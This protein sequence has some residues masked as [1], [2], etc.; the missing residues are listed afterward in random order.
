MI[1]KRGK[2]NII[3]SGAFIFICMWFLIPIVQVVT[4]KAFLLLLL[5]SWVLSSNWRYLIVSVFNN[6]WFFIWYMYMLLLLMFGIWKYGLLQPISFFVDVP[7]FFLGAII[8]SY[9]NTKKNYSLLAKGCIVSLFCIFIGSINS[10]FMLLQNP[11]ASRILATGQIQSKEF[12]NM[13]IGGYGYVYASVMFMVIAIYLLKNKLSINIKMKIFLLL[14]CIINF[15][16]IIKASYTIAILCAIFLSVL[17]IIRFKNLKLLL[18]TGIFIIVLF[19]IFK[20]Q[21]GYYLISLASYLPKGQVSYGKIL[22]LAQGFISNDFGPESIGRFDLYAKSIDVFC[23]SP[24]LGEIGNA[25]TY[26]S[27]GRHSAWFD[28]LGAFGLIGGLPIFVYLL[29]KMSHMI[30]LWK[31]NEYVN[32]LVIIQLYI[33][34]LGFINPIIY[35]YEIG[36][37]FFLLVPSFPFILHGKELGE[38]KVKEV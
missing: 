27:I 4:G 14:L 36:F 22:D 35:S 13:G 34:F 24:F 21:V 19:L 31:S 3:N 28:L 29:S 2:D 7:L 18:F 17:S 30:K 9:Y 32:Y 10:F 33:L 25:D 5:I 12:A 8:F 20:Q 6:I 11:L 23:S 1:I 15:I 37:V 16:F 26:Y 38:N